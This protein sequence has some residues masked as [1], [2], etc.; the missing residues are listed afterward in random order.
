MNS[1][2]FRA[3]LEQMLAPTLAPGDI[4]VIKHLA[5]S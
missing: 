5:Q 4:V 3:Y 2:T 1:T